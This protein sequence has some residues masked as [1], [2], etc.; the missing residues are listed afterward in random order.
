MWVASDKSNG[1]TIHILP[2]PRLGQGIVGALTREL[3]T[4]QALM[5]LFKYFDSHLLRQNCSLVALALNEVKNS[6]M[7][8]GLGDETH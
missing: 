1:V 7:D 2:P 3:A 5:R 8:C 4:I 6:V